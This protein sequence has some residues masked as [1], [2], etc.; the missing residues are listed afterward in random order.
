MPWKRSGN[1]FE[2]GRK[3][4]FFEKISTNTIKSID[5]NIIKKLLAFHRCRGHHYCLFEGGVHFHHLMRLFS[6]FFA[7]T[8]KFRLAPTLLQTTVSDE[9]T[10][11]LPFHGDSA[12]RIFRHKLL[13]NR[14]K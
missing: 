12:I 13:V 6:D 2:R 9:L 8:L 11:A 7:W 4:G 1:E 5:L 14:D 10:R 3:A